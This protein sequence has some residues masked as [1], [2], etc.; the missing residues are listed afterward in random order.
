MK[1]TVVIDIERD[2]PLTKEERRSFKKD[3]PGYRL[4]IWLRFPKLPLV[5]S[6]ISLLLVVAKTILEEMIL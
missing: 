6:A 2:E 1:R 5:I 4:S 3:H